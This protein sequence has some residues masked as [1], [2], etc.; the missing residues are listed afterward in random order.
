MHIDARTLSNESVIEGDVCII[1]A[2]ASGVSIA[3]EWIN[4]PY[5]VI[6][7]E[8]G[9]FSY[10]DEVQ[11]LYGGKITGQP[12]YPLK[13]SRLHYFGG[14]TG[15][16]A[17][18]CST[19]D[20][21]DF[22]KRDWV[23][24]SG[25]VIER[26]D[27]DPFYERAHPILE[28]GPYEYSMEYWQKQDDSMVPLPFDN[29]VLW[30][31]MWQFSPPTRFGKKYKDVIVNAKNLTLYTYAN[32]VNIKAFDHLKSVKEVEVK[33]LAGKTHTVRAKYFIL[34][35]NGIQNPRILLASNGQFPNGLGNENDIVGRYFMEHLEIKSAE[36][37][38]SDSNKMNLYLLRGKPRAEI[39]M[40]AQTQ[41]KF[42]VL[43][44]TSSLLPLNLVKEIKPAIETWSNNDPRASEDQ[45]HDA[46]K[47]A[48][49]KKWLL[50]LTTE[51]YKSYEL[52]TRIE[53]HPNPDSRITLDTEKDALGMP[54]AKLHWK[55]T[56]QEKRSVRKLYELIGQQVGLA[57]IGRVKLMEYLQDETD[58][59]WPSFTGGGWHHMGATRMH[60]DPKKSVVD[61][62]CR[63][64]SMEN[65]FIAGDSCFTTGGAI[66]PTLTI[67]ALSLRLSDHVKGLM[68]KLA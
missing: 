51:L 9:G 43:N 4:S 34:A 47:K 5:K 68:K 52:F 24:N 58:Q 20:A 40:T 65:L 54:R 19:M 57:G 3:L 44:G 46:N 22:T 2:G 41:E 39:S 48:Y 29:N 10:E 26:K 63:V 42:K 33:N 38:L 64:H 67:V 1:G 62:N 45:L 15:H 23:E 31:K 37:W 6:L 12:Y 21:I 36:L 8:G 11:D 27:L 18:M 32:V 30:N 28:L 55:L 59:S 13:S 61:A 16:W 35:C 17:G 56:D 14:T 49:D 25:W 53:Q 50:R 66:N 60:D 7:L